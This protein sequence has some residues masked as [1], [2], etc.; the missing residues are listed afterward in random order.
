MVAPVMVPGLEHP[1]ISGNTE[2]QHALAPV[3]GEASALPPAACSRLGTREVA[4][5]KGISHPGVKRCPRE[6]RPRHPALRG[7]RW[8]MYISSQ[9]PSRVS[10]RETMFVSP[11]EQSGLF[12]E[13]KA[14]A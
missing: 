8:E 2:G 12:T 1:S 6:A 11:D 5:L 3:C 14:D 4:F 7:R 13:A 9:N 10:Q